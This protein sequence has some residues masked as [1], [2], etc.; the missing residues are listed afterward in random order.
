MRPAPDLPDLA[1]DR[2][3]AMALVDVSRE[4]SARL[5]ALV[6]LLLRWTATHNLIAPNP[7]PKLWPRHIADSLQL[8]DLA[9][10]ARIWID[11]G[12]GAG[13]PGLVIACALAD[14]PGAPVRPGEST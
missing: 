6:T 5:D 9:P 13:F 2:S 3:R 7:V 10:D 11:L 4:T 8:L 12:S 1:A 14:R